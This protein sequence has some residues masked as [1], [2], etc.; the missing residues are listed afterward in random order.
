MSIINFNSKKTAAKAEGISALTT[1]QA[2]SVIN[3]RQEKNVVQKLSAVRYFQPVSDAS[4][5]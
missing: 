3:W 2:M 1:H 4:T 5:N